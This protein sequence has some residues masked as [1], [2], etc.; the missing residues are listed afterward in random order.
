MSKTE[1]LGWLQQIQRYESLQFLLRR[2]RRAF[3]RPDSQND[4]KFVAAL[5]DDREMGK[6]RLNR[7]GQFI[8]CCPQKRA[9]FKVA[10]EKTFVFNLN[11]IVEKRIHH[12]VY[13]ADKSA[14]IECDRGQEHCIEHI[15]DRRAS[16]RA[17]KGGYFDQPPS[18][19]SEITLFFSA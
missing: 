1:I 14:P 11:V 15:D 17:L 12:I 7:A 19:G 4:P 5:N 3:E 8:Q 13:V 2:V 9:G 18:K 6:K 10:N 16:A